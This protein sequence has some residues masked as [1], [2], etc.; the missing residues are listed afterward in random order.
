M[1]VV[2]VG[3][4]ELPVQYNLQALI[5]YADFLGVKLADLDISEET[6]TERKMLALMYS[7]LMAAHEEVNKNNMG[8]K[9]SVSFSE[10]QELAVVDNEMVETLGT[11]FQKQMKLAMSKFSADSKKK[12]KPKG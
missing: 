11:L 10:F 6:A 12:P 3:E 4:Q 2:K 9:I 7:G 8:K 5:W 1:I